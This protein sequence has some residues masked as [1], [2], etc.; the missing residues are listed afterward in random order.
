M[1]PDQH[2]AGPPRARYGPRP[3]LAIFVIGLL[4]WLLTVAVTFSTRNANL[5]P[6]LVLLGSFLVPVTF[7]A[8]AFDRVRPDGVLTPQRLMAA[9]LVGGSLGVLGASVLES[10]LLRPSPW[11][12]L[13]VGLIEEGVKIAALWLMAA[14]LR[15]HRPR[16]GMVLGAAVGFGF[17]ALESSGYALT[18]LLTVKGLS[19]T[20][21][22][23]TEILRGLLAPFGH[24]LWTAIAGG[25]LFAA[26][27]RSGRLRLTGSVVAAWL[28]L[29]VL[30]ALWDAM[31]S[32]AAALALLFTGTDWQWHLLET[33][34]VPR[35]TSAQV[36]FIT[37]L[38]WGG[39]MVVTLVALGWLRALARRTRPLDT[40]HREP[41]APWQ[42]W[43]ER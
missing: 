41:A 14:R 3:W 4:L 38:Q 17:A 10:S 20:D 9:F 37:G 26:S 23:Q 15:P 8:W 42:G 39:W 34:Y 40:A 25:V 33:G 22:V 6:T 21:L 7:V 27:A 11:M 32:L 2:P 5:V 24:G 30:H 35:P 19:L 16:D 18:A 28:G 1:A 36:G 31:H 29:S 43:G 12:W 13:G